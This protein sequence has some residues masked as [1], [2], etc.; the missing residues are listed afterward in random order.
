MKHIHYHKQMNYTPL[1][2]T[3]ELKHKRRSPT[4]HRIFLSLIT[5]SIFLSFMLYTVL[6]EKVRHVNAETRSENFAATLLSLIGSSTYA[7]PQ[8]LQEA[9]EDP[10]RG[11]PGSYAVAVKNMTTGEEYYYNGHKPFQPASVY[12]VWVMGATMDQ[13]RQGK[14]ADY[15]VLSKPVPFLNAE[16]GI[17]SDAAEQKE[18]VISFTV[19]EALEAMITISHNYAAHLL[20]DKVG[21]ASVSAYMARNNLNESRLGVPPR[22][23][24]YDAANFFERLYRGQLAD[25]F[26]TKRMV[27]LLKRNK[28]NDSLPK[29]LPR[30]VEIAHKTGELDSFANDAGI[31]YTEKGDYVIAVFSE[32][33][34]DHTQAK[35]VIGKISKSVYAY[36]DEN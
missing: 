22:I 11:V 5:A 33:N 27:A 17:A 23:T 24:A 36:F 19:N 30:N 6:K 26:Y 1:E 34:S 25:P 14:L 18:G 7:P 29:Y 16:F 9:V 20:N 10:L 35:D 15:Q 21:L 4:T 28:I 32:T 13:L 3:H 8:S 2:L 12:K 31:V